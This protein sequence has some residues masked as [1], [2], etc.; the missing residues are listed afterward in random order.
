MSQ[1]FII[2]K[3]YYIEGYKEMEWMPTLLH[4]FEMLDAQSL[5]LF[6]VSVVM[7]IPF[8]SLVSLDTAYNTK[9]KMAPS[10]DKGC[11]LSR[12]LVKCLHLQRTLK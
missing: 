7:C 5:G 2:L 6:L 1:P 9:I 8:P 11:I 12:N 4:I 10:V 3:G